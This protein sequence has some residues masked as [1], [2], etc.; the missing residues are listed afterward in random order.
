[1]CAETFVNN[2]YTQ[3]RLYNKDKEWGGGRTT[4]YILATV[5]TENSNCSYRGSNDQEHKLQQ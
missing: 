1:M 2:A 4:V 3:D 5:M